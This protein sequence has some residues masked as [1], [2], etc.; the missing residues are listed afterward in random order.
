MRKHVLMLSLTAL[1]CLAAQ[2]EALADATSSPG[3]FAAYTSLSGVAIPTLLPATP[4]ASVQILKGKKKRVLEVDVTV[5]DPSSTTEVIGVQAKVNGL[6]I[7]EP[8]TFL[9]VEHRCD[10]AYIDCTGHALFWLDIDTAEA[11]NPGVFVNQPIN[12][13]VY[14]AAGVTPSTGNVSVRARLVKK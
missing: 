8:T 10:G 5:V 9:Q 12:V 13:D 14:L 4:S 2:G 11:T 6:A 7:L 3:K 1:L